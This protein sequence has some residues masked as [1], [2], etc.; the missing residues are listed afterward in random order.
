MFDN[1]GFT[2]PTNIGDLGDITELNLINC[3]LK[4]A[5]PFQR[6]SWTSEIS[7][8]SPPSGKIPD[9]LGDCKALRI[10]ELRGNELEGTLPADKLPK[11]L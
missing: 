2:L 6:T 10:L 11:N 8:Y 3:S 9:S 1:A 7:K 4:G 5:C